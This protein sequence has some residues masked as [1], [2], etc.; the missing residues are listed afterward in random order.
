M[1]PGDRLLEHSKPA[2]IS[3]DERRPAVSGQSH[4]AAGP[5]AAL[6][7][8]SSLIQGQERVMIDECPHPVVVNREQL[9]GKVKL[10]LN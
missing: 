8:L 4:P 6:V 10:R 2:P 5:S 3:R 1:D 9:T 7:P